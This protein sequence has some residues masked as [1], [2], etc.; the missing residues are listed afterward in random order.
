MLGAGLA[1]ALLSSACGGGASKTVPDGGDGGAD[2][3]TL[4]QAV[5]QQAE[6]GPD[7]RPDSLDDAEAET[8][9]DAGDAAPMEVGPGDVAAPADA[10]GDAEVGGCPVA[11]EMAMLAVP[12]GTFM[13]GS[14]IWADTRPI[15]AVT[16]AS[17]E[18]DATE[19][20]T[21]AYE[22][23][24]SAGAC[25]PAAMGT[26][27]SICNFG[28]CSR[29]D[30]P[31][32]CVTWNQATAYCGW[33]GK[34]LPSEAEWEYAARSADNRIYTWGDQPPSPALL[35]YAGTSDGWRWSTPVA[36]YPAGRSP[37]GIYDMAG[38]VHEWT[39]GAYCPYSGEP[40]MAQ[41]RVRRGSDFS[42][43][44]PSLINVAARAPADGP[45]YWTTAS[46]FR[47]AR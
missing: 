44:I 8:I 34:R 18:M 39:A 38:N 41:W 10:G 4:D 30:H 5:D 14:D 25:A 32:N 11:A 1:S 26:E 33:L 13:M 19:V 21:A 27:T 45:D 24:V 9:A 12:G 36:S 28:V 43:E 23:C 15:H 3:T 42:A 46:G 2:G 20:T 37:F 6:T 17:F 47:C 22:A 35:N 16:V 7:P 31:I 40:C 29:R